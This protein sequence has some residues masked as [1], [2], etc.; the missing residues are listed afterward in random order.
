MYTTGKDNSPLH[1]FIR[2][3]SDYSQSSSLADDPKSPDSKESP[4]QSGQPESSAGQSISRTESL[5]A[6]LRNPF[7]SLTS[8][9]MT[10]TLS[11]NTASQNELSTPSIE[12][13]L[14]IIPFSVSPLPPSVMS[15]VLYYSYTDQYQVM[16][17]KLQA[18]VFCIFVCIVN[19]GI[20][21]ACSL[22]ALL[23]KNGLIRI[24]L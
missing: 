1:L 18:F 20:D 12:S 3:G 11:D 4:S 24:L 15:S 16:V 6:L 7:A 8:S 14:Q 2:I 22:A 5:K 10:S 19:N 13:R 21:P 9:Q 23:L 17:R